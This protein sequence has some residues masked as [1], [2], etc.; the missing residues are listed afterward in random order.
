MARRAA[1]SRSL[2]SLAE[3]T[4]HR[5]ELRRA[6]SLYFSPANPEF[7]VRF[8]SYAHSEIS[9]EFNGRVDE[10]DLN[11]ISFCSARSKLRFK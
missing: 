8:F 3:I 10:V 6:L 1:L 11:A 2:Q 9:A 5:N 4:E 7:D